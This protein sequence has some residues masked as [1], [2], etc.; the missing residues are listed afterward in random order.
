MTA[1]STVRADGS[2][3]KP[4]Q[5]ASSMP[6]V[7]SS[8]IS[9]GTLRA[10]KASADGRDYIRRQY[11]VQDLAR[12]PSRWPRP[13]TTARD[14]KTGVRIRW[15]SGA[16]SPRRRRRLISCGEDGLIFRRSRMVETTLMTM[17]GP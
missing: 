4:R 6:F 5:R 14:A 12:R 9:F 16:A 17:D 11:S 8:I 10:S 13:A 15:D 3:K 1:M 7:S 2:S